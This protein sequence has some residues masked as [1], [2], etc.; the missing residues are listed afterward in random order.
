MF[1]AWVFLGLCWLASIFFFSPLLGL[2]WT[3]RSRR[4][5]GVLELM[6]DDCR[7]VS[8]ALRI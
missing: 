8:I 6:I 1:C 7:R 4:L 5:E 3:G 2:D